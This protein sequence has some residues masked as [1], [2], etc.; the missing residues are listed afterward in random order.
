V[1]TPL[2][3]DV[4]PHPIA[5]VGRAVLMAALKDR[6]PAPCQTSPVPQA[7][8]YDGAAGRLLAADAVA[9][10]MGCPVRGECLVYALASEQR[11]GI[12]G[13]LAPH[14]RAA[15]AAGERAS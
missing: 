5:E 13:G 11:H 12:W 8:D 2:D 1:V 10:C 9:G 4:P 6:G 7:W 3:E 15:L 14:E